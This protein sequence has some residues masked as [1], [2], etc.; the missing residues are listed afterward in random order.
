MTDYG[1]TATG[2]SLQDHAAILEEMQDLARE[3]MGSD[4]D[5]G[6]PSPLGQ[7]LKALSY[8]FARTWQLLESVYYSGYLDTA[9]GASLD[10]VVAILGM[11]RNPATTAGGTVT[12]ARSSAAPAGGLLI[13]AGTQ[14]ATAD[15]SVT[16]S[17][18]AAVT[19]VEGGTSIGAAVQAD[20][21]GAGGNV[22]IATIT[23]I[24][25][26][27]AG[28]ETVT[29]AAAMAG[30]ADTESDAALRAR[31]R[32]YAPQARA[33]IS[34]LESA[35]LDVDGVT[36]AGIVEDFD[37]SSITCVVSGGADEDLLAVIEATRPAGIQVSLSRPDEV[38]ITVTATVRKLAGY[39]DEQVQ[40][41]VSSAINSYLSGLALG[42]DIEYS[43]VV[44]AI[45]NA[46]GV[47]GLNACSATDGTTAAD[48]FGET[49]AIA[50]GAKP[51]AGPHTITVAA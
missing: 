12:F 40:T 20:E 14:V 13:P 4:I 6:D 30:G 31:T 28:I 36:A 50:A 42:E 17:T 47:D 46:E 27:V 38:S 1:V 48:A 10:A 29:N 21:P 11:E 19:L 16:F 49:I 24:L 9:Q 35:L 34:A 15:S 43:D 33:T 2:F 37:T 39:T 41:A 7:F 8:E 51:A 26:P 23:A 45:L 5:L 22:A 25:T 32:T 44:G 18:S 3:Y